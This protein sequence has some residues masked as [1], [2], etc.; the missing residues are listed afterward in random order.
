MRFVCTER[1]FYHS[2]PFPYFSSLF[3][4]PL[5]ALD[6]ISEDPTAYP[7]WYNPCEVLHGP[8]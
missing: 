1:R 7:E 4:P 2:A 6:R 5:A 8:L 3:S